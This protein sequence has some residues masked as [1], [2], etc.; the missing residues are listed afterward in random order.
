MKEDAYVSSSSSS[1]LGGGSESK[2]AVSD[3]ICF[4]IHNDT[5]MREKYKESKKRKI[6]N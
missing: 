4:F 3:C 2:S 5:V 1:S 6:L